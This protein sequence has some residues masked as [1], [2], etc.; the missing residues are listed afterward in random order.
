MIALTGRFSSLHLCYVAI[1][2]GVSH[3]GDLLDCFKWIKD[4]LFK[5]EYF[6]Y[7][8]HIYVSYVSIFHND[9]RLRNSFNLLN[10][11]FKSQK[12]SNYLVM[13]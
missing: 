10:L 5:L 11:N 1:S 7:L 8:F 12:Y 3:A 4:G 13:S 6:I 9:S 2:S